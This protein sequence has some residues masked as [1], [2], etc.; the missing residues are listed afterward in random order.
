MEGSPGSMECL[1][2]YVVIARGLVLAYRIAAKV[3]DGEGGNDFLNNADFH[4]EV[5]KDFA[6]TA[7]GIKRASVVNI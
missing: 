5:W 1:E 7:T 4:C 2:L 6:N 3:I